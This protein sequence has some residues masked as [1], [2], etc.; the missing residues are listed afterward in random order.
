MGDG[1]RDA[2][3]LVKRQHRSPHSHLQKPQLPL[4][5]INTQP[6]PS[7]TPRHQKIATLTMQQRI[8]GVAPPPRP[9][10]LGPV[11][12]R[13]DDWN[14]WVEL[15]VKVVGLPA[16]ITTQELWAC[17]RCHGSVA[18]IEIMETSQGRRDGNAKVTFR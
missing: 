16:D 11:A 4:F 9:R 6:N 15:R 7:S 17:F 2:S 8:P 1:R 18:Q 13:E 5:K 12:R 3:F 10:P 14:T